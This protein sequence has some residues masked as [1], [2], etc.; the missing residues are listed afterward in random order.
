MDR[1]TIIG[2]VLLAVLFFGYFYYSKQGQLALEKQDQHIQ[3][4]INR[5]KPK[6]D[7][8]LAKINVAKNT[9]PL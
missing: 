7:S 8:I 3:D 4:S 1:N 9:T 2:F 5:L 6:T